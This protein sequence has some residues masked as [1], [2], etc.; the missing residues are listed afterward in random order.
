MRGSGL[1]W[2][3]IG[4]ERGILAPWRGRRIGRPGAR[5]LRHPAT[6]V[7][8]LRHAS[9]LR[10]QSR[11][12]DAALLRGVVVHHDVPLLAGM[13]E[14]YDHD[15]HGRDDDQSERGPP[16]RSQ[17][18]VVHLRDVLHVRDVRLH[19]RGVHFGPRH[20][21][22]AVRVTTAH[23]RPAATDLGQTASARVTLIRFR[24]PDPR[25]RRRSTRDRRWGTRATLPRRRM[26]DPPRR[27]R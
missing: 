12:A 24:R 19:D 27:H 23:R 9:R 8:L 14:G 17:P 13:H 22:N 25:R 5:Q 3:G 15:G 18:D 2:L 7:G 20:H 4:L 16:T 1:Q 21:D 26:P 10:L 11:G 6:S